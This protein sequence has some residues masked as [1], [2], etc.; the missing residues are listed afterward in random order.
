MRLARSVM[1]RRWRAEPVS[2]ASSVGAGEV[3]AGFVA[4][5]GDV[6]GGGEVAAQS[7]LG[8]GEGAVHPG[9]GGGQVGDGGRVAEVDEAVAAPA[10]QVG[11]VEREVGQVF[12][13]G[14]VADF[15]GGQVEGAVAV[16][17]LAGGGGHLAF[18][19]AEPAAHLVRDGGVGLVVDGADLVE[20]FGG[21]AEVEQDVC[22]FPGGEG[23]QAVV[24]GFA[25][26]GGGGLEVVPGGGQAAHVDGLPSGQGGGV[27]QDGGELLAPVGAQGVAQAG[28]EMGDVGFELGGDRGGA[29]PAVEQ[30]DGVGLLLQYLDDRVVDVAGAGDLAQQL[31]LLALIIGERLRGLAGSCGWLL[32]GDAEDGCGRARACSGR[33][34]SCV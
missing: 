25:G 13:A 10:G 11:V 22:L 15:G 29:E 28:A 3:A 32:G 31:A 16:A 30:P 33:Q 9:Q 23:E 17:V 14:A 7:C 24:V 4:F 34:R 2:W 20:G 27:G 21:L 8:A 12:A 6:Q 5:P 19:G 18:G 26:G 1:R